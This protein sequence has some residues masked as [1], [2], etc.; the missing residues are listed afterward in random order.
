MENLSFAVSIDLTRVCDQAP[1][2]ALSV[3]HAPR[4]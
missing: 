1:M 2:D 3:L 4:Q